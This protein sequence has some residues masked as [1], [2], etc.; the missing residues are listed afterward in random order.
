MPIHWLFLD[1][2]CLFTLASQKMGNLQETETTSAFS[3]KYINL[4]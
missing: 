3:E 2:R 4:L 1:N